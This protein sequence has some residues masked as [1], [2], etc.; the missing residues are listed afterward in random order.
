MNVFLSQI[1]VMLEGHISQPRCYNSY[2]V[3]LGCVILETGCLRCS[4]DSMQY[5]VGR[6]P[7]RDSCCAPDHGRE[8]QSEDWRV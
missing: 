7:C 1:H 8:A 2:V 6:H 3:L 5:P 4:H